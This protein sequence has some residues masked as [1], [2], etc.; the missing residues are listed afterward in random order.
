MSKEV[1]SVNLGGGIWRLKWHPTRPEL[2]LSACMYNGFHVVSVE[3]QDVMIKVDS[4]MKHESIAYGADWS[5][6]L[7][8]DLI[9]TCSFYDHV[10]HLNEWVL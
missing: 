1:S 10:F 7:D 9:G 2:L 6:G 3:S 8:R 5:F 4:Y